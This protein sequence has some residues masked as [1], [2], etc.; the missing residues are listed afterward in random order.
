VKDPI[1]GWKQ[2]STGVEEGNVR[3]R[4]TRKIRKIKEKGAK[5]R[6]ARRV[7]DEAQNKTQRERA[8]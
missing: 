7:D 6:E 3:K 4:N 5:R 8:V 2:T 1:L